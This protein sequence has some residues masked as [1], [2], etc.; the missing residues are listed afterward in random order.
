MPEDQPS[1]STPSTDRESARAY[2]GE[3]WPQWSGGKPPDPQVEQ[4]FMDALG[5]APV[6][7]L[8]DFISKFLKHG[9]QQRTPRALI[10]MAG[11]AELLHRKKT[12]RAEL[13]ER[14]E[15]WRNPVG[16]RPKYVDQHEK[17]ALILKPVSARFGHFA[18]DE[19]AARIRQKAV[20]EA[21]R[22]VMEQIARHSFGDARFPADWT[23]PFLNELEDYRH[24]LLELQLALW[25]ACAAGL[26]ERRRIRGEWRYT[27]VPEAWATIPDYCVPAAEQEAKRA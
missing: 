27:L 26:V 7:I 4:K 11:L 17:E 5:T 23:L 8:A 15:R 18:P 16:L 25:S 1:D 14:E 2:F 24:S 22:L 19:M 12:F 9:T 20:G 10:H 3:L 21:Q 6:A 13:K